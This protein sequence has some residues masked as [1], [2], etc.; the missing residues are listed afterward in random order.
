[1]FRKDVVQLVF[2]PVDGTE[3]VVF[4]QAS[5]WPERGRL[6]LLVRHME[7]LG[8]GALQLAYEQ[9]KA[10]LQAEGLFD[11]AR[12]RP[13]PRMPRTIGIVTALTG[14]AIHDMLRVLRDRWP[15]ARVVVRPVR[16]QGPGAAADIAEALADLQRGKTI[17]VVIVGRGGG[18][19]EDLWAFNEEPVARAI[20]ACRIPIVSAV[21]HESDV[22]IA[23]FA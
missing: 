16:V 14:A 11:T 19:L 15:A 13:L 3:V 17:D 21:G 2:T 12:K 8:V 4:G 20:A 5:L 1:M 6:Q 23:D 9:L 10:R 22:T 7:P 18:S